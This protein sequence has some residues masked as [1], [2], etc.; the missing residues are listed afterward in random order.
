MRNLGPRSVPTGWLV[1]AFLLHVLPFA[2]RPALIGGDEPHYAL[3]AY[4]IAVDGDIE[5]VDDYLEVEA[6]ANYAGRKRA[7]EA[8]DQ[9]LISRAGQR[10]FSHALGLPLLAAPLIWVQRQLTPNVPPDIVLGVLTLTITFM[11][12]LA[13]WN[14]LV[15][16]LRD[17]SKA[18]LVVASLYF[19]TPVWFYS[20]TFFTEPYL[21][22][23]PTLALWFLARQNRIAASALLGA[24]FLIKEVAVVLLLPILLYRLVSRGVKDALIVGTFPTM[25]FAGFCAKNLT[26]FGN[27]FVTFQ[28]FQY[29]SL[30]VGILGL[31]FSSQAGLVLYA[32]S[33]LVATLAWIV[34]R[35]RRSRQ[36]TIN[37]YALSAFLA[38][39]L[40][41]AA[42]TDWVGGSGY[43]PRL[44][45][46]IIPLLAFPLSA[47]LARSPASDLRIRLLV[48]AT[49][50][51]FGIQFAAATNPVAAFWSEGLGAFIAERWIAIVLG[52]GLAS[53]SFQVWRR[54]QGV[55]TDCESL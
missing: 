15:D 17:P 4:S 11:A 2:A 10:A 32:P 12:L 19:A 7:G 25:A 6:G 38:W 49:I 26:L 44:I 18:A 33:A 14:L 51:G 8:L 47:L 24:T 48:G 1:A 20:R 43:G 41:A 9:H 46:P 37:L 28:P 3:M 50:L 29:G 36:G 22:A 31:L 13:G 55:G 23:L 39:F 35:R 21:W 54:G 45:V 27:P 53:L 52:I 5:L 16:K 34:H 42:W 40:L 30:I